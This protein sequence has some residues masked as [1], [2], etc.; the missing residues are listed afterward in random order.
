MPPI[1]AFRPLLALLSGLLVSLFALSASAQSVTVATNVQRTYG[2]RPPD[3]QPT[4]IN[5]ADC[6]GVNDN[7]D[8]LIFEATLVGAV[9]FQLEVWVGAGTDCTPNE[10]RHG[11]SATCWLV[12][13][14]SP[15][16]SPVQLIINA[17]DI[18]G[19]HKEADA[20]G[21]GTGTRDDC[22][23]ATGPT[24]GTAITL[25][26]MLVDGGGNASGTG[27]NYSTK[28]DLVGPS[29]PTG[30]SSGIGEDRLFVK[31]GSA[32]LA[33]DLLGYRVYC[34]PKNGQ[35][36]ANTP[37]AAG[38]PGVAGASGASGAAGADGGAG[39]GAGGAAGSAGSAGMAGAAGRSDAGTSGG[40]NANC[41]STALVAGAIPD[42][43]YRCG[44]TTGKFATQ[45]QADDLTN[46][47]TY[48]LAVSAVDTVGNSGV[49]STV[50][51]GSPQPVDDFFELYRRA[52]GKGG[53]G[54]CAIGANPAPG[55]LALLAGALGALMVRRRRRG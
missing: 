46:F 40:G 16:T 15:Q 20:G 24:E 2:F 47:Q 37:L 19:Q 43:T 51:C 10:A 31:W 3:Q 41:P 53:G 9:G 44:A 55:V 38:A 30:L 36:P 11:G 54:F 25:Y 45:V 23:Q 50:V 6:V 49:L 17:R 18:V 48:A 33:G 27:A 22:D 52:G 7:P 26:F 4:W 14:I 34:D 39:A 21:P 1:S 32:S 42:E 8:S 28:F 29:P 13:S 35:A 5:H 12:K